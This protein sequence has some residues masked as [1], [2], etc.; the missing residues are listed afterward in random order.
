MNKTLL[1]MAHCMLH[2]KCLH[3][4]FW[5]L[6]VSCAAYIVNRVSTKALTNITLEEAWSGKKPHI[7][8]LKVFR[9]IAWAHILD[10]KRKK[11]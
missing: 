9:C 8:Y 11:L 6:T 4:K 3:N 2:F 5:G 10:E 1:E 7:G